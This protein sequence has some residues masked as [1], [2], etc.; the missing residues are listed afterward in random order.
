[1]AA[2]GVVPA[3]PEGAFG[4]TGT[5]AGVTGGTLVDGLEGDVAEVDGLAAGPDAVDGVG[6]AGLDAGLGLDA[7]D[8]VGLG[9]AG[10]DAGA[11]VGLEA[12]DGLGVE[13]GLLPGAPEDPPSEPFAPARAEVAASG[14]L[15]FAVCTA[16]RC[17]VPTVSCTFGLPQ[18]LLAVDLICS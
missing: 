9:V 4:A 8:G 14:S 2:G 5:V 12:V 10:P 3:G 7:D 15:S 13:A 11:D 6:V 1:M 17:T 16:V 18:A